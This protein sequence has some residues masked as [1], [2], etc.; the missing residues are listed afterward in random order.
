MKHVSN[1]N[2]VGNFKISNL[3]SLFLVLASLILIFFKGLNFG[4]DF[5]G[6]L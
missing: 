2:F 3:S 5:K 4:I 6:G 1:Y